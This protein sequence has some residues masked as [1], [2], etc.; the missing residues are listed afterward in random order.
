VSR[1]GRAP[2]LGRPPA[3]DSIRRR[4]EIVGAARRRFAAKGYAATALSAVAKDAGITLAAVY[5]YFDDKT[6][7]YEAVFDASAEIMWNR[8]E[9]Q[10]AKS[11]MAGAR[12][13]SLIDT[14]ERVA[15]GMDDETRS[16]QMFLTTVPL[17]AM[18]H[19]ELRHLLDKRAEIQERQIRRI[20]APA[21]DAGEL[22]AFADINT[23]VAAVRILI[24]GWGI[25][26]YYLHDDTVTGNIRG[27]AEA[28]LKQMVKPAL[29][30]VDDESSA[31]GAG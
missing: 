3:A 15:A 19:P 24:M 14:I 26:N 4:H 13:V 31:A 20:V 5:H 30:A 27:A 22:P 11:G 23:A 17:D 18:R 16:M 9:D 21:F 6:A 10:A 29:R 12:I 1:A 7:L 8:I 2:R 28:L 25:E